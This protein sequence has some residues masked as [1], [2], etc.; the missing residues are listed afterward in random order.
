MATAA[1]GVLWAS[2]AVTSW[3]GVWSARP[4][5]GLDSPLFF[6]FALLFARLLH[7]GR[8]VDQ[9]A[10]VD[11]LSGLLNHHHLLERLGEEVR[12][13]RAGAQPLAVLL[14][15]ADNLRALNERFGQARGDDALR[16]VAAIVRRSIR[17]V[18]VPGRVTDAKFA[19]VLPETP[20][21]GA[22]LVA[23]RIRK[24]VESRGAQSDVPLTVSLGVVDVDPAASHDPAQLLA[25][26][27]EALFEA[28]RTG[29]N[30]IVTF[31]PEMQG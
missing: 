25:Q 21:Q 20:P 17:A 27:D 16:D 30:R 12:R 10:F 13:A 1:S 22:R 23:E 29:R 7:G 8:G 9:L 28:K 2:A 19:V 4:D 24:A 31:D 14:L 5:A 15:D 11:P 26:A 6:G 18:D 3:P